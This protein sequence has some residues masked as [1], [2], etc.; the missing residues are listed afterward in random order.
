MPWL[1]SSFSPTLFSFCSEM[2]WISCAQGTCH[3]G[4]VCGLCT[5]RLNTTPLDRS[6]NSWRTCSHWRGRKC[7]RHFWDSCHITKVRGQQPRAV[8]MWGRRVAEHLSVPRS[9]PEQV[10]PRLMYIAQDGKESLSS[11]CPFLF[12]RLG[13]YRLRRAYLWQ[14]SNHI[15]KGQSSS[16]PIGVLL[17]WRT[18]ILV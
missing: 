6:W 2:S 18:I 9:P 11:Y 4:S 8:R 16:H 15:S 10:G 17:L 5:K 7:A 3:P 12:V 1:I 13:R 14:S